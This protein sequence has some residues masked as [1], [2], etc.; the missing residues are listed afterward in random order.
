M[1]C[2]DLQYCDSPSTGRSS[3]TSALYGYSNGSINLATFEKTFPHNVQHSEMVKCSNYSIRSVHFHPSKINQFV[4]SGD[5]SCLKLF[6]RR[7]FLT[8]NG[9]TVPVV[10]YAEHRSKNLPYQVNLDASTDMLVSSGVDGMVRFWNI[11]SGKL[12]HLIEPFKDN[13]ESH[14]AYHAT[15]AYYCSNFCVH[16]DL[17]NTEVLLAL[18]GSIVKTYF[19]GQQFKFK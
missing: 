7:F 1:E 3:P 16:P 8:R 6:D 14:C 15:Q 4:V 10:S 12:L 19:S 17:P 11:S 13:C 18:N 5:E 9:M 2:F